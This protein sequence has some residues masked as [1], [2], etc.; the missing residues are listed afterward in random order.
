MQDKRG[1]AWV[2]TFGGLDRYDGK[3]TVSFKPGGAEGFSLSASVVFALAEGHGGVV[4]V[5]TDGGGLNRLNPENGVIDVFRGPQ[6][7][8][9]GLGSDLV[10]ALAANRDGD[11][12]IG[13]G[14]NG[15]VSR[16]EKT[17]RFRHFTAE[18]EDLPSNVVRALLLDGAG[19]LW[20]GTANGGLSVSLD[21]EDE[22]PKFSVVALPGAG[23]SPTVR[24]IYDD[25]RGGV[26]VGTEGGL[27][28]VKGGERT[29]ERVRLPA[30]VGGDQATVRALCA[31][32]A[33]RIWIGTEGSGLA[34]IAADGQFVAEFHRDE[35]SRSGVSGDQVRAVMRDRT[36]LMWIGFKDRGISIG[37]PEAVGFGLRA[38]DG[39]KR[40]APGDNPRDRGGRGE[41]A[42]ARVGR[43]RAGPL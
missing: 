25:G 32:G 24:S 1:F 40:S 6:G 11:L 2:G 7:G 21:P 38:A 18:A 15:L 31:D 8:S 29:V 19:R 43:R 12:W 41:D 9:E 4:W 33:G 35:Y 3:S 30:G 27:F 36:G 17:G 13:T 37:N 14:G 28:V 22:R 34:I 42:V 16:K 26:W 20:V 5:G 10:Y 23:A 39:K